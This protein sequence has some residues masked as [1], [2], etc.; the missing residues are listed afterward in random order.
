LPER[1]PK[2]S[3]T[4][5]ISYQSPPVPL[6]LRWTAWIVVITAI[7]LVLLGAETTTK[8][9]GMAD[10]QAV[11]SPLYLFERE[12]H[13]EGNPIR[14]VHLLQT[15]QIAMF[16]EHSHRLF[17]WAVGAQCLFLLAPGMWFAARGGYRWLGLLALTGVTAQG[18]LGIAR[19]ALNV[20]AGPELAALH[21]CSAQIVFASLVAVA[22]LATFAWRTPS[23]ALPGWL[24]WATVGMVALV[25]AQLVAGAIMR[26]LLDPIAMRLHILLAFAAVL[27]ILWWCYQ[28]RMHD[29]L[30]GAT[31]MM[32]V[33]LTVLVLI[34]PILG[35][36]AWIRRFGTTMLPDEVPSTLIGDTVR[37][38]HHL[39][40][41]MI[42]GTTVALAALVCRP[43]AVQTDE[44]L[45]EKSVLAPQTLRGSSVQ[46]AR[47][48]EEIA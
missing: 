29:R 46:P 26:H 31:W 12:E 11:R 5:V 21:G 18:L 45:V 37:S 9:A 36:E 15:M 35:V 48:M 7:P 40:G 42:F 20:R 38:V 34:Q 23:D 17:G 28:I 19:V 25:Y 41:T 4:T 44:P 8:K 22:T 30:S 24:R 14:G 6:W 10:Q 27:A 32:A 16:F 3:E 2:Q 1:S 39:L 47:T 13:V 43:R 33:F